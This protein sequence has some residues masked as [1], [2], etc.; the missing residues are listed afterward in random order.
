LSGFA[1]SPNGDRVLVTTHAPQGTVNEDLWLFD[2]SRTAVPRRVTFEPAL[3]FWP[4]WSTNDRFVFGSGGGASGVYD[5]RVDGQRQ[6]LFTSG[7]P[8]EPTSISADGRVLLYTTPG[9]AGMGADVWARTGEGASA[10]RTPLLRGKSDQ[11]QGQ[12]SADSRW[13][14]YVSNEAG[15]NDVFVSEFRFD[16]ATASPV[17]GESIRI[18]EG[19]GFAPR[20]RRDGRELLYLTPDGSV[21]AIELDTKSALRSSAPKRLFKVPGAIPEWGVT[22]DGTRFLFAVPVSPLPPFNVVQDWQ[23]ALPK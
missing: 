1:L 4:V 22:S 2:L 11:W 19:G 8:E 15:P 18:S 3:E 20:W 6:L 16:S 14:A 12:L 13:V 9:E 23:A 21:M 17:A 7:R 10:T 5:Q